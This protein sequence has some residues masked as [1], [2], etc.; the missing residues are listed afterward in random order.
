MNKVVKYILLT[1]AFVGVFV[2]AIW[3]YRN[4]D[5][6]YTPSGDQYATSDTED[7]TSEGTETQDPVDLAPDFTVY[8]ENGAE[9]KLSDYYGRPIVVN[10][11]ATWC[12]PCKRE[13][14][15]FD[16]MY[17]KYGEDVVFLMVNLTAYMGDTRE[18]ADA[19]IEEGKYTF[20]VYYDTSGNAVDTYGIRGIPMTL[21]IDAEGNL[22]TYANASLSA[23]LLETG[24]GYIYKYRGE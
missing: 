14:P 19:V 16:S 22:V 13:M 23:E 12:S 4:L 5:K 17:E 15:A 6:I 2:L 10:F 11:W 3:G 7:P 21:F 18:K 8:D 20:P 1:L 9:V 24:L